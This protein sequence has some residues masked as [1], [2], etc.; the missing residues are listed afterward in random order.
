[1]LCNDAIVKDQL[2]YSVSSLA[3]SWQTLL[4]PWVR[5]APRSNLA[6]GVPRFKLSCGVTWSTSPE[7]SEGLAKER[8]EISRVNGG[9]K[10][11]TVVH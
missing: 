3:G 2:L 7:G 9:T 6:C 1:M 8:E 5:P 4:L 11:E 10:N